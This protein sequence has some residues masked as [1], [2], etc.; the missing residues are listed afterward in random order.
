VLYIK[1]DSSLNK[2]RDEF[3]YAFYTGL[4]YIDVYKFKIENIKI[5][6]DGLQWIYIK[7]QKTDTP[8]NLPLLPAALFILKKYKKP[9]NEG[10]IF[11]LWYEDVHY[12]C[13]DL[14]KTIYLND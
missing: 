2:V 11:P 6:E 5:G 9:I 7:R 13:V 12:M 14:H 4:S 3:L 8:S 1:L 10:K